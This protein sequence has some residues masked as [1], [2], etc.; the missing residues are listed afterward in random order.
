MSHH[1]VVAAG[2]DFNNQCQVSTWSGIDA[3][4]AGNLH[5]VGIKHDGTAVS[6]NFSGP[7]NYG[8]CDIDDWK[9]IKTI[10]AGMYHTIALTQSGEIMGAGSNDNGQLNI[11][12]E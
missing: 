9:N 10:S 6:T 2:N 3:I 1:T 7:G 8:Q 12:T 4:S 5:T 11:K